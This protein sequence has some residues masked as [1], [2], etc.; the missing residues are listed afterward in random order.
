MQK[1]FTVVGAF[2]V[3]AVLA[4][5]GAVLGGTILWLIWPVTIPAVFPGIVASGVLAAKLTWWQAVFFVWV[6][7]LLI[8]TSVN[9]EG[10]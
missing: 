9:K 3:G 5:I 6:C 4:F 1:L 8:K 2:V 7:A 10:K